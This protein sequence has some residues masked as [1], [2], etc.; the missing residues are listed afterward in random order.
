MLEA[1]Y[2]SLSF[3]IYLFF[4]KKKKIQKEKLNGT[5]IIESIVLDLFLENTASFPN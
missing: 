4:Q 2:Y 5:C 3:F 1:L